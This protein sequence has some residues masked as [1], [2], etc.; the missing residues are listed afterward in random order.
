MLLGCLKGGEG[1]GEMNQ[2]GDTGQSSPG[3]GSRDPDSNPKHSREAI[4]AWRARGDWT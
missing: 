2:R 1:V 3:F 4:A